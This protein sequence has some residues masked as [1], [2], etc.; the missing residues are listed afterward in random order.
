MA[1]RDVETRGPRSSV[2]KAIVR[3]LAEQLA[4]RAK[5]DL[6]KMGFQPWPP[7]SS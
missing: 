4:A 7:A 5:G 2:A 6:L 1:L 3:R